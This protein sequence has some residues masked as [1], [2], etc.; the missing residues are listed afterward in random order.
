MVV[1]VLLLLLSSWLIH[2]PLSMRLCNSRMP[3]EHLVCYQTS[4]HN[5]VIIKMF[6]RCL[7]RCF[8]FTERLYGNPLQYNWCNKPKLQVPCLE[9]GWVGR[10]QPFPP[11][12][13]AYHVLTLVVS[14]TTGGW[15]PRHLVCL[16]IVSR[17]TVLFI[18]RSWCWCCHQ[19]NRQ[20]GPLLCLARHSSMS[21]EHKFG[22][23]MIGRYQ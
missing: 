13:Y 15:E 18:P 10:H 22:D 7:R 11:L 3:K 21:S 14:A 19:R 9:P 20:I 8:F 6:Y 12:G 23:T 16:T 2:V 17:K 4:Q 5:W 1:T